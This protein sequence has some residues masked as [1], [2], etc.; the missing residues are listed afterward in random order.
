MAV[1]WKFPAP[2]EPTSKGPAEMA[3][4]TDTT[5]DDTTQDDT[6]AETAT[7]SGADPTTDKATES[8]KAE[9]ERLK[10][11]L[12]EANRKAAADRKRLE[13]IDNEAKERENAKLGE[14]ERLKKQLKEYEDK[15]REAEQRA[16]DAE[17]A[18][19]AARINQEIERAAIGH[20][21]HPE[22]ASQ[23]VDRERITH[24]PDTGKISGIKD[25]IEAVLKKYPG[26]ALAQ[27]GGGSPAAMTPKRP[28]GGGAAAG[29][30][31]QDLRAEFA[32]AGNY[33]PL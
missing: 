11:A 27:R 18:V 26:L 20:F 21:I 13:D 31:K 15:A 10:K 17:A 9:S 16:A 2:P 14:S 6:S 32:R 3:T 1:G 28:G 22:L 24:D 29:G 33:E 12:H 30:E 8:L 7:K 19:L 4:D 25:A 23:V 5:T